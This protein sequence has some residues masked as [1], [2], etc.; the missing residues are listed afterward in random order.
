MPYMKGVIT[1]MSQECALPSSR[2]SWTQSYW[3]NVEESF[4]VRGRPINLTFSIS[5]F[6]STKG[7]VSCEVEI[8]PLWTGIP[9]KRHPVS[10]RVF[11]DGTRRSF[12]FFRSWLLDCWLPPS[13]QGSKV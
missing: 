11:A 9:P 4:R 6:L 12:P 2:T 10:Q 5:E 1:R 13:F 8:L 3:R 7:E